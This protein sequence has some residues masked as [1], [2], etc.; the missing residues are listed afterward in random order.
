MVNPALV[1]YQIII[2]ALSAFV[3]QLFSHR[4]AALLDKRTGRPRLI[5]GRYPS[6][7]LF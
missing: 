4:P 2:D 6:I 5:N 3:M 7:R 1:N